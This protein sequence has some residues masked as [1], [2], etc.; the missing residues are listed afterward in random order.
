[1]FGVVWFGFYV[2]WVGVLF[3]CGFGLG[4]WERELSK[5]ESGGGDFRFPP[6]VSSLLVLGCCVVL[7]F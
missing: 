7:F 2:G 1:M 6:L 4:D 5:A 3:V